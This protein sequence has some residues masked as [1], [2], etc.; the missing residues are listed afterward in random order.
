[1]RRNMM[2]RLVEW[3]KTYG[4]KPL[5]VYGAR[6][7]GKTYLLNEFAKTEFAND[8]VRVDLE[9]DGRARQVFEQDLEPRILI[10][11]LSQISGTRIDPD[12][13][14][15]FLDEIQ[16][17]NR[18]L[19]SLKYFQE[20]MPQLSVVAAG[21]LL[22]VAVNQQGFTAPVGKVQTLTLRPMNFA[23]FVDALGEGALVEEIRESYRSGEAFYLHD[24]MLSRFWQYLLVGGM[25]EAVAE[26]VRSGSFDA[27]RVVQMDIADLYSADMAKYASPVETARIRDTW[28]SIPAQLAKE[29]H[30]FQYKLV[31]SGGRASVYAPAI[32]WLLSAGLVERCVRVSSGRLPLAMHED[33][34]AFKVYMGDTGLL[35][36]RSE[37]RQDMVMD[38][39][40]RRWVDLGGIVEN[41]VAQHICA[42]GV[43]LRYWTSGATAEV[44]FV[45]QMDDGIAGV[46]V[47]VKSSDNTRSRSLSV[48]RGKYE[49]GEALRLSTK[50]FGSDNGIRSV[51]LYAAFCI[52]E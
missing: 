1:M 8:Y 51:P 37:L 22:G 16:A 15:L 44:D 38:A 45:M 10:R 3:R 28:N 46:P 52:G 27:V 18:A 31:H 23:E 25:P 48:Y 26:Y 21:S 7:T 2:K 24:E 41:Y 30:K 9:R 47:E 4:H 42:N 14:L 6:Q 50:N 34:A 40:R 29:N 39:G 11:R 33:A 20:D 12:H 43:P 32:S 19:A 13:T 5:L 36:A 49:P 17:S 35:S